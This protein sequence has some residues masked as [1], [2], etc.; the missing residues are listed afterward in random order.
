[1]ESVMSYKVVD[2]EKYYRKG[3]FEHFSNDC[4]CS[5]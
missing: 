1:M 2:K 3:V 5:T 4:K